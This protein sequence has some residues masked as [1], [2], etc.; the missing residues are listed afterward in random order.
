MQYCSFQMLS[1][2]CRA[3]ARPAIRLASG[4][5]GFALGGGYIFYS[6]TRPMSSSCSCK[7]RRANDELMSILPGREPWAMYDLSAYCVCTIR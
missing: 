2:V 4:R 7:P 3:T 6:K 1:S 5:D